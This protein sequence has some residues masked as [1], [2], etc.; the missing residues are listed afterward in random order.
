MLCCAIVIKSLL[1]LI[2]VDD[3][4][5][6][7]SSVGLCS[8]VAHLTSLRPFSDRKLWNV[9]TQIA[10]CALSCDYNLWISNPLSIKPHKPK[11]IINRFEI[12][13]DSAIFWNRNIFPIKRRLLFKCGS[14]MWL[15][16]LVWNS[17]SSVYELKGE[18]SKESVWKGWVT[19]IISPIQLM[20]CCKQNTYWIYCLDE[21]KNWK[22]KKFEMGALFVECIIEIN[23][24][25]KAPTVLFL[26][27]DNSTF[28]WAFIVVAEEFI[29]RLSSLLLA[30]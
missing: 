22:W 3:S 20:I 4:I 18:I 29:E 14:S 9:E 24:C 7:V 21:Y 26:V 11:F 23:V 12:D 27:E 6:N 16:L 5:Q 25:S 2:S 15:G 13:R 1:Y 30:S 8:D 28:V 17:F 19:T 10:G